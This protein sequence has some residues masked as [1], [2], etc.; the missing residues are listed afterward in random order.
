MSQTS[1][2][3]NSE[4]PASPDGAIPHL[5]LS[6]RYTQAVTF[7]ATLHATQVRKGGDIAY[8]S[9]LLGVSALVIEA[10]GDEDQAIAGLLHD[11]AEDCGGA[12]ILAVI[13]RRFGSRVADTVRGCSDSLAVDP[14][15][16]AHWG[17]RKRSYISH[18]RTASDDVLIVCAADKLHN[19]RAIW[20]DIHVHGAEI[21]EQRF[22]RPTRI[23][24]YY[25]SVLEAID[26]RAP[27]TLTRPLAEV[28]GRLA[29][30]LD[31]RYPAAPESSDEP[32]R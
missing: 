22:T 23:A 6:D 8:I 18:L 2:T 29:A 30:L 27:A 10:R 21:L 7:A 25:R 19:A 14:L 20:N 5:I 32:N 24:W 15:T 1:T 3:S 26:G 13:E 28:V 17:L 4:V 11:S 12:P 31:E 16:K 9:H